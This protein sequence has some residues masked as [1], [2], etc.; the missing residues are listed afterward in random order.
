MT[1]AKGAIMNPAKNA[2]ATAKNFVND[3]KTTI[4]IVT[5]AAATAVIARK[6]YGRAFEVA[7]QFITEQGL[8]E[9]FLEYVPSKDI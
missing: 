4:A 7:N 6:T 8:A 5:T 3:H 9:Q 2:L 1:P